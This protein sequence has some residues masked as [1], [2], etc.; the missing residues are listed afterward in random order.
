MW[1]LGNGNGW[2]IPNF[3][4]WTTWR[5]FGKSLNH[6]WLV[7]S[8]GRHVWS[9]YQRNM[10]YHIKK[11]WIILIRESCLFPHGEAWDFMK[12]GCTIQFHQS[13]PYLTGSIL[14]GWLSGDGL[15][16]FSGFDGFKSPISQQV[17]SSHECYFLRG[18]NF[19]KGFISI[20]IID[21]C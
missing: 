12:L 20:G 17:R 8:S 13:S 6:W 1:W 14:R 11:T 9:D 15:M 3:S 18:W 19:W 10:I 21:R 5:F 7:F 16:D 2:E 4:T